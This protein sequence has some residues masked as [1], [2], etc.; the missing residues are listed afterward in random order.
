MMNEPTVLGKSERKKWHPKLK[1]LLTKNKINPDEGSDYYCCFE[2]INRYDNEFF[3]FK[4]D[5]ESEACIWV[6]QMLESTDAS[7]GKPHRWEIL[8]NK[9]EI[10]S[11]ELD[12][13]WVFFGVN[14]S[15]N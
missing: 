5:S 12:K 15:K 13:L 3:E 2:L 8:L 1:K 6:Q 11:D 10:A 14:S 7:E 4:C 9:K